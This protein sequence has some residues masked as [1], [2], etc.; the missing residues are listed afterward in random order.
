MDCLRTKDVLWGDVNHDG[1]VNAIDAMLILQYA[2]DDIGADGL[3]LDVADVSDDG[4][5]NAI[6]A[7]LILQRAIDIIDIFPVEK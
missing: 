6:D 5:Y 7:M 1:E 2:I 3:D 4:E